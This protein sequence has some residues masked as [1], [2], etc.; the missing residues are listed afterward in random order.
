MEPILQ[1]LMM[2]L[3]IRSRSDLLRISTGF[4]ATAPKVIDNFHTINNPILELAMH[5]VQ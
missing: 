5:F 4:E 2:P 1:P 3:V